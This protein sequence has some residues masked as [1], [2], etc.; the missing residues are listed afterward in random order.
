M[1]RTKL[2]SL[3]DGGDVYDKDILYIESIHVHDQYKVNGNSDLGA[4]AIRKLLRC[5]MIKGKRG[6]WW[7]VSVCI[8]ILDPPEAMAKEVK[9]EYEANSEKIGWS[10]YREEEESLETKLERDA[11]K[12]R[13]QKMSK[14]YARI[15]AN[16]FLRNG[17]YQ[18]PA[19]AKDVDSFIIIVAEKQWK[20]P[21]RS[22]SQATKVKF[23][24]PEE[25][26]S[27]VG[28]DAEILTLTK[29]MCR[30]DMEDVA[31][32]KRASLYRIDVSCLLSGGGSLARS[33]ALHAACAINDVFIAKCILEMDASTL[34]SRDIL[35]VT[36]L[37]MAASVMAGKANNQGFPRHHP[38]IDTLLEAGASTDAMDSDGLTAYGTFKSYHKRSQRN[39]QAMM[40]EAVSERRVPGIDTL[41]RKLMP[42]GGPTAADQSCGEGVDQGYIHYDEEDPGYDY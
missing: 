11:I 21:L 16:Q 1:G 6:I 32:Q 38:I 5:D 33:H 41:E 27:P 35:N 14:Y 17:F 26:K 22:H 18:D 2:I 37:M 23:F 40:G 24:T 42:S 3:R 30:E 19:V 4:Y 20:S 7:G 8:Y 36:P 13:R 9:K 12:E 29:R 28:K 25:V 10:M 15:D 34:E 39:I 31:G